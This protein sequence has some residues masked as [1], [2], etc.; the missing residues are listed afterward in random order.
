MI[1]LTSIP[2]LP[3]NLLAIMGWLGRSGK[4]VKDGKVGLVTF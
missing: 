4:T 3:T 1:L 2:T